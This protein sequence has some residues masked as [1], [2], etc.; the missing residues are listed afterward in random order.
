ML[1]GKKKLSIVVN[2]ENFFFLS[3]EAVC[4]LFGIL[5]AVKIGILSCKSIFKIFFSVF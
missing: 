5:Y 1:F 2:C 4:G 3:F